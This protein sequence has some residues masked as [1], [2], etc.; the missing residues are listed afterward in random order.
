MSDVKLVTLKC[1]NCGGNLSIGISTE[2]FACEYCGANVA[3]SRDGNTAS[4]HLLSDGLARI[5]RGTDKAAAELAIRRLTEEVRVA[6]KERSACE[7]ARQSNAQFED[8]QLEEAKPK[9][10]R[11]VFAALFRFGW[12][13]FAGTVVASFIFKGLHPNGSSSSELQATMLFLGALGIGAIAGFMYLARRVAQR[14]R[15][16]KSV[17]AQRAQAEQR[18][19]ADL[20]EF[21]RRIGE[22]ETQLKKNRQI[23]DS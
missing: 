6:R 18:F 14:R 17:L 22:L 9:R 20:L 10:L 5:Q 16:M 2:T 11:E 23:A 19:Q 13:S 21:D 8:F 12:V 1:P 7:S 15:A 4:L 3:V